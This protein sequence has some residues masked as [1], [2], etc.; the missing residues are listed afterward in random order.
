MKTIVSSAPMSRGPS[1]LRS[2]AS[3]ALPLGVASALP[4]RAP[5]AP[6]S[7]TSSAQTPR[8][9]SA[10][11]SSP[12]K[13]GPSTPQHFWRAATLHEASVP[14]FPKRQ[15]LLGPRFGGDDGREPWMTPGSGMARRT[16]MMAENGDGSVDR[17]AI[18]AQAGLHHARQ[19]V[20]GPIFTGPDAR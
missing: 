1:P 16:W 2:H 7:R 19:S 17:Q 10:L 20:T 12:R 13:R 8:V 14:A 5:S 4:S 6:K 15:R 3:S 18:A 11:P 9:S